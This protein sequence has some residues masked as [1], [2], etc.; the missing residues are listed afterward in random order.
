MARETNAKTQGQVG[1]RN[2]SEKAKLA[3]IVLPAWKDAAITKIA[4][5]MITETTF[6]HFSLITLSSDILVF[7]PNLTAIPVKIIMKNM[8]MMMTQNRSNP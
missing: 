6:P 2:I 1:V 5:P 3:P 7:T 4:I 8:A